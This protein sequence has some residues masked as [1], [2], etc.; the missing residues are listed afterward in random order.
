MA[1]FVKRESRVLWQDEQSISQRNKATTIIPR[2]KDGNNADTPARKQRSS[3]HRARNWRLGHRR[4]RLE[5][6]GGARKRG[7][8]RSGD[9]CRPGLWAELDRHGCALRARPLRGSRRSR[10]E[11]TLAASVCFHEVRACVGQRRKRRR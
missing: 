6:E 3:S 8:L 9:P 5:R 10:T 4:G 1:F 2:W 7:A 11:G